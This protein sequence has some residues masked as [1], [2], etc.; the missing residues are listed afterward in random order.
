VN[1]FASGVGVL[2]EK[3]SELLVGRRFDDPTHL[4]VAEFRLRLSFELRVGVFDRDDGG[5]P[6][7]DVFAFQVGVEVV[8]EPVFVRVVV[9][10][11]CERRLESR[12]V[13]ATLAGVDVVRE[14]VDRAL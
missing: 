4:A 12:E 9:D 2:L 7:A 11:A 14:R 3:R 6:L 10:N 5:Q 1:D 8:H 13:C